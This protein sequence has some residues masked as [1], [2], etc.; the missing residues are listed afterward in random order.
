[1]QTYLAICGVMRIRAVSGESNKGPVHTRDQWRVATVE[2]IVE[3]EAGQG[4]TLILEIFN[5]TPPQA[6]QQLGKN[7]GKNLAL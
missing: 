5:D 6:Q 4:A 2:Y 7:Q 3:K 1:M